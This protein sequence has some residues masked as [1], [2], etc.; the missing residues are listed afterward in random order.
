M[1]KI[2]VKS[3]LLIDEQDLKSDSILMFLRNQS[4]LDTVTQDEINKSLPQK[5]FEDRTIYLSRIHFGVEARGLGRPVIT[6]F[7]LAVDGS[8]SII[9]PF[10]RMITVPQNL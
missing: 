10:N 9:I 4:V 7:G 6:G 2:K 5:Y 1:V 3:V 8:R